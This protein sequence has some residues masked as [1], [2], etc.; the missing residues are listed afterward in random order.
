MYGGQFTQS[1]GWYIR[2]NF[3]RIGVDPANKSNFLSDICPREIQKLLTEVKNLKVMRND[4]TSKVYPSTDGTIRGK[5]NRDEWEV[6]RKMEKQLSKRHREIVKIIENLTREEFGFR[7]VGEQWV[8]ETLLYQLVTQLYPTQKIIRNIRP[9]WLDGL[10]L[11]IYLPE[12][13]L[14]IEYQGQQ[15]YRPVKSW[16]GEKA[17]KALKQRDARKKELCLALGIILV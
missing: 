14:A 17:L 8:S 12:I 1:Y 7:K 10:E 2:Q 4:L 9:A 11:D 16:G 6:Q 15:H 13:N 3:L 5:I